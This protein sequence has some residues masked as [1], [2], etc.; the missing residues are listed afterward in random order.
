MIENIAPTK[1][2]LF[3]LKDELVQMRAGYQIIDKKRTVLIKEMIELIEKAKEIQN[4]ANEKFSKAYKK[5]QNANINLGNITMQ[6]IALFMDKDEDF[7]IRYQSIMGLDVPSIKYEKEK[8]RPS[9]SLLSTSPEVDEVILAF[10][11]VKY[12]I[13][14]LAAI[15][16]K[17]YKLSSEIKKNQKRANALDKI[18]IPDY[19]NTIKFISDTL[20]EKEREEFFRLKKVKNKKIME[21]IASN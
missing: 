7:D 13:Y 9:Y 2:N 8:F 17:V 21:K 15:E 12:L 4:L 19:K 5:L 1:A 16:N 20:E 10:R 6:E 14:E 18:K 3:K 11:E